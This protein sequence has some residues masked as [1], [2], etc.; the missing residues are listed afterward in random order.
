[1]QV[2]VPQTV[3][4]Q[5]VEGLPALLN[6]YLESVVSGGT[7]KVRAQAGSAERVTS[8][9]F[10]V[11]EPGTTLQPETVMRASTAVLIDDTVTG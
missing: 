3:T 9:P 8:A 7:V 11:N 1:M 2:P 4:V 10:A 6:R 5:V